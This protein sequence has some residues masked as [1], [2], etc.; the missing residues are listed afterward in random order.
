MQCPHGCRPADGWPPESHGLAVLEQINAWDR[1]QPMT[2][3]RARAMFAMIDD[4][5]V[6]PYWMAM[7]NAGSN[8]DTYTPEARQIAQEQFVQAT[9]RWRQ[10][11]GTNHEVVSDRRRR[12]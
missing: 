9:K 6:R 8:I 10:R 2:R 12:R 7:Q 4:P 1:G 3:G 11:Q 5:Q